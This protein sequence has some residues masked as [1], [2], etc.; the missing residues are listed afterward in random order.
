MSL[1][2]RWTLTLG[3]VAALAIGLTAGAA[4][5][6]AER[7]L[8]NTV[9]LDLRERAAEVNRLA[10]A[11]PSLSEARQWRGRARIVDFD[12]AVQVFDSDG[13]VF[14]RIGPEH[15]A[16]PIQ[17]VD[18]D[19]FDSHLSVIRDVRIR[20][21]PYRMITT[22]LGPG[23]TRQPALA[24]Q[25]A[26]DV[27]RVNTNLEGLAG[28][29]LIIGTIGILLVGLT[30]WM[31]ASRAVRPIT[32]LT[33]AAEQIAS[34]ER[35]DAGGNLD[36]SAPAEIGRLA[37]AFSW[38]LR[39]LSRSRRDQQ[40]LVADASH[41]FRTPITALQTNLEILRRRGEGLSREQ[42]TTIIDAALIESN[43][44]ASL[45]AELVD[46]A[47]DVHG[48]EESLTDIDLGK[49]AGAVADRHR[50]LG[51]KEIVVSGEGALVRGRKSQLERALGNLVDNAVKW[52]NTRVEILLDGGTVT[53]RDDGSG[54][55]ET[56]LPHIFG[57]F[58]RSTKARSTPGSGL[59]LAIVE[60]L[61]TA[62]GGT[63]FAKNS[64]TR[65]AEVGFTLGLKD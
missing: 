61:V 57:R 8:R 21:A 51:G 38:M 53:V 59:G 31:L 34:S 17:S 28:R 47:T 18:L 49:L 2:W 52:A 32:E 24:F 25:V 15:V 3:L 54:I 33:A 4:G 62:H 30:G 16:P 23:E 9:D 37:S 13:V 14:L 22:L 29:L 45:A 41:E 19:V 27:S 42:R 1:R 64:A 55:A 10:G 56:D 58:Y 44:L 39:A 5:V 11:L 20:G 60:H 48:S 7:Q 6:A 35:L 12:A 50:R 43:Q 46:L 63:V 40:R 65:G 26:V 36:L